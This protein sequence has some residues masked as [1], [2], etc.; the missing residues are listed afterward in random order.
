MEISSRYVLPV[1]G[2]FLFSGGAARSETIVKDTFAVNSAERTAG[3]LLAETSVEKGNAEWSKVVGEGQLVLAD[4]KGGAVVQAEGDSESSGFTYV[5]IPEA[6][7]GSLEILADLNPGTKPGESWVSAG[8]S[9][10]AGQAFWGAGSLWITLRASGDFEIFARGTE[11][12]LGRGVAPQFAKGGLN[13]V[14]LAYDP[15][16]NS[17]SAWINGV[18]VLDEAGLDDFSPQNRFAGIGFLKTESAVIDNFEVRR[19]PAR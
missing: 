2:L 13:S 17:A 1:L 18:K 4:A 14:R 8:F 9:A 16:T 3:A 6:R 12:L 15:G 7:G 11:I 5:S 19:K 10:S